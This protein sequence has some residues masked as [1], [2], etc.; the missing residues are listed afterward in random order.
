MLSSRADSAVG[1]G[2]MSSKENGTT[3]SAVDR[4]VQDLR[5]MALAATEGTYLGSEEML[6]RQ[7]GT[8]APTLRQAARLLEHEGVLK[9]KRGVRGGYYATRPRI[10]D[11]TRVG[12]TYLRATPHSMQHIASVMDAVT[13]LVIRLAIKSERI[14]EFAQFLD[15]A[16][17]DPAPDHF[18]EESRF[19]RL[20]M[21]LTGNSALQLMHAMFFQF[22]RTVPRRQPSDSEAV[23]SLR[24]LRVSLAQ[25]LIDGD[26]ER[27][28]EIALSRHRRISAGIARNLAEG[29]AAA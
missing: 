24:Q 19:I 22:G 3:K 16:P 25:A 14:C 6:S 11:I 29:E 10:D 5:G 18:E 28:T 2:A 13:P 7:F 26:V 27:A 21:E 1:S 8:S 12:G 17:G 23:A 4:I 15:Q 20:L 9:V